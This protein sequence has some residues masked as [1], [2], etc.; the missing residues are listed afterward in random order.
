MPN[1]QR[2]T[3]KE[4]WRSMSVKKRGP[5]RQFIWSLTL[6]CFTT[7]TLA[8]SYVWAIQAQEGAVKFSHEV[9]ANDVSIIKDKPLEL[10]VGKGGPQIRADRQCAAKQGR[11]ATQL[12]RR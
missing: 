11:P 8:P 1:N 7:A 9:D 4:P 3:F 10:P 5:L 2:R 12:E 6:L